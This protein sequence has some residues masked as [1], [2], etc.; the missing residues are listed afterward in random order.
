[1]NWARIAV[2]A[3][4]GWS[5]IGLL[6]VQL[7]ACSEKPEARVEATLGAS[8]PPPPLAA[9]EQVA[10]TGAALRARSKLPPD[11]EKW[12]RELTRSARLE[13][14]M[15]APVA[16]F[17]AQIQ[18][19]SSW[20]ADATSPVG[21]QGIAQFMP[22]TATWLSGVK[23]SLGPA[24]P[25]NPVWALRALVAYDKTLWEG[26]RA[27]DKCH[28]A[29]KTLSGYNG[30]SGWVQRDEALATKKGLDAG[31]WWGNVE[32][33]NAGRSEAAWEE[34]RHYPKRILYD[35]EPKYLA[36]GWEGGLCNTL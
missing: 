25:L 16:T 19:E 18:Q 30:G 21:A 20:R 5:I 32:I 9:P 11:A 22:S 26:V 1:M 6:L 10:E 4:L 2:V 34:N 14:G 29:A 31:L 36:A 3:A 23:S 7:S 28:R 12:R 24:D 33:V 27:M 13:W 15:D 8:A 35:L 17:G